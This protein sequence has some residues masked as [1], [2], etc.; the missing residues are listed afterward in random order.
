MQ[1]HLL[2][3]LDISNFYR[4]LTFENLNLFWQTS[5]SASSP[6][7]RHH[8]HNYDEQDCHLFSRHFMYS[9]FFLR[10]S[11]AASR[12]FRRRISLFLMNISINIDNL[13]IIIKLI[14]KIAYLF[15]SWPGLPLSWSI[16]VNLFIVNQ[17]IQLTGLICLTHRQG[18]L[19]R[20][21]PLSHS[22]SSSSSPSS[23]SSS[24][25]SLE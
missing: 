1:P 13:V 2:S 20:K 5:P 6:V 21:N 25:S 17:P 4:I 19:D 14:I 7:S 10:H 9:F 23:K 8:H 18:F 3:S 22:T 11:R 12:F 15:D 24:P 16:L